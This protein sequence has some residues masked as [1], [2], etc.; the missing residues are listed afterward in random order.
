MWILP[1]KENLC[2]LW[3]YHFPYPEL[4]FPVKI[5]VCLSSRRIYNRQIYDYFPLWPYVIFF[6]KGFKPNAGKSSYASVSKTPCLSLWEC[7]SLWTK[8]IWPSLLLLQAVPCVVFGTEWCL[9]AGNFPDVFTAF[10]H[11]LVCSILLSSIH[12]MSLTHI[13]CQALTF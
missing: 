8:R 9:I 1:P 7:S 3:W 12:F 13:M 4:L 10:I 11:L 2:M 5:L 6:L